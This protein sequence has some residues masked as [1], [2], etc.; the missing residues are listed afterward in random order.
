VYV[1]NNALPLHERRRR[2]FW[3]LLAYFGSL[4]PALVASLSAAK[5][6]ALRK[7]LLTA[8]LVAL[9]GEYRR[10]A[11]H[12]PAYWGERFVD[13]RGTLQHVHVRVQN[14]IFDYPVVAAWTM[15]LQNRACFCC[16]RLAGTFHLFA[17]K[18]RARST[19]REKALVEQAFADHPHSRAA[20]ADSLRP[21]GLHPERNPL[22]ALSELGLDPYLGITFSPLHMIY[23]GI[24]K[25]IVEGAFALVFASM[26]RSAFSALGRRIDAWIVTH[27]AP[28]PFRK[29]G[30]GRGISHYFYASLVH[31]NPWEVQVRFGKITTKDTWRDLMR[32]FRMLVFDLLPDNQQLAQLLTD[33][34]EWVRLALRLSQTDASLLHAETYCE[35]WLDG[36]VAC[37]GKES[38]W[39]RIKAHAPTHL[40]EMVTRN[41]SVLFNDDALG[42]SAHIEGA[43]EP[44]EHT[45]HINV[46]PQMAATVAR[47]D[48]LRLLRLRAHEL[49]TPAA[50]AAVVHESWQPLTWTI[51][52]WLGHSKSSSCR[53]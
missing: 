40:R 51:S 15:T 33:Y 31:N 38:I 46:A 11:A 53:P 25:V 27:I 37:F 42:E 2:K 16:A 29:T 7:A 14:L 13:A 4:P 49:R 24:W 30:F 50:A 10:S 20:R 35:A 32:F 43:K 26:T 48:T 5:A 8:M 21:H 23:E 1:V 47:R 36:M 45:N 22:W 12:N 17:P 18:S 3:F 6:T 41:A 9:F 28:T 39:N 19:A 52:S 44:W 34:L